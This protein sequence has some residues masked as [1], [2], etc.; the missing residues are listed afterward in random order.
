VERLG[1]VSEK[2]RSPA[3]KWYVCGILLLA[4]M[5]NYMDRMT[6]SVTITTIRH[7]FGLSREQYGEFEMGFGLA[8]AL[9]GLVSG[10]LADRTNVRW[11]YP[12]VLTG[13]SFAG[14]ATAYADQIGAVLVSLGCADDVPRSYWGFLVCRTALGFFEA[15]QWPCALVTSQR[16]LAPADRPLGNSLLQSG[17]AL[18]AIVTPLVVQVMVTSGYG[19]WQGPFRLIGVLGLLWIIPWL[20][21]VR[22]ADLRRPV[23]ERVVA[24]AA[25]RG[26]GHDSATQAAARNIAFRRFALLLL[27]VVTINLCFQFFRAWLPNYLREFHKYSDTFV[28]GF[29]SA[30][31]IAADVGCLSIGFAVK[32]L[33]RFGWP[34]H[35]ARMLTFAFCACLTALSTV[36]AGLPRGPMLLGILLL[37]GFGALGLFPNYYSLTQELSTRHQ[38]KVTGALGCTTWVCT[39]AMQK[40]VG[41]QIEATGSYADGIFVVG[42]L[43]LV[44]CLALLLFWDWPRHSSRC[45]PR[46]PRSS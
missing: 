29:T 38:G 12:L 30:Y 20:L 42:L 10:V 34:L 2:V 6:L 43:P 46:G 33:L 26:Q 36:A 15:G 39:A 45:P 31:Y 27:T 16:L 13:W 7:D 35:R 41:R 25:D 5:L 1:G 9:G 37:I 11:L 23:N 21:M 40:L 17:A 24:G 44:A 3:W 22:D 4:T 28:N 32:R 18:G 14:I 19:T 8:F